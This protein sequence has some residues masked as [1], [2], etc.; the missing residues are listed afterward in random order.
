MTRGL[1]EMLRLGKALGGREETIVGLAGV[2]DLILTCT[3]DKSRNRRFGL[4]LGQGKTAEEALK[5]VGQ[6]VEG[7]HNVKEVKALATRHGVSM[8]VVE[9]VFS[10]CYDKKVESSK[11]RAEEIFQKVFR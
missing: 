6:V 3:D 9:E 2:G 1:D 10:M 8:P 4:L 11:Q 5:G 7:Y